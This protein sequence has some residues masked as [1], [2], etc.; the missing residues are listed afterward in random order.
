[1]GRT[2]YANHSAENATRGG[3]RAPPP[4]QGRNQARPDLALPSEPEENSGLFDPVS[5][6][7]TT[8][9]LKNKTLFDPRLSWTNR[10]QNRRVGST[11]SS[12]GSP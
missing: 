12:G 10:L 11:R 1:M 2:G 9:S 7:L 5:V 6:S 8:E 4:G 3:P